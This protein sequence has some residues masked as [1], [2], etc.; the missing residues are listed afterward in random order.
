VPSSDK[1]RVVPPPEPVAHKLSDGR[2]SHRRAGAGDSKDSKDAKQDAGVARKAPAR[3]HRGFSDGELAAL[4]L[5]GDDLEDMKGGIERR[6]DGLSAA[7]DGDPFGDDDSAVP[8]RDFET[9]SAPWQYVRRDADDDEDES[10]EPG[11]D[12]AGLA[13]L[14]LGEEVN[15]V[16]GDGDTEFEERGGAVSVVVPAYA[17]CRCIGAKRRCFPAACANAFW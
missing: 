11:D 3:V 5:S 10:G 2:G 16:K 12:G 1:K 17:R 14:N 13:S 7:D 15:E 8:P 9:E 6:H 4:G